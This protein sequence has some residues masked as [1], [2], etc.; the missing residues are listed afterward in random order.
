[1]RTTC[2]ARASVLNQ[3]RTGF[4]IE[5]DRTGRARDGD[6]AVSFQPRLEGKDL[7]LDPGRFRRI[8]DEQVAGGQ[9]H[10]VHG[11]SGADAPAQG[12]GASKILNRRQGVCESTVIIG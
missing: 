1:M 2:P 7:Y 3:G 4:A 5:R 9:R 11:A 12:A 8:A 6:D 10:R